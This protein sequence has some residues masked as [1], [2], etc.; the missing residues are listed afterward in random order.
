MDGEEC[1]QGEE[2]EVDEAAGPD[3]VAGVAGVE[4]EE[5]S[6][7]DGD[8]DDDPCGA[9]EEGG[10][11]AREARPQ[12]VKL[13][14]D[15]D[16]PEDR[17]GVEAEAEETVVDIAGEEEE[18]EEAAG[19][20]LG[21]DVHAAEHEHDQEEGDVKGPD[22]KH[23][24]DVEVAHVDGAGIGSL[25]D[26]QLGDEVGAEEEEHADAEGQG[27]A[28]VQEE[29]GQSVAEVRDEGGVVVGDG[30]VEEDGEKGAEAQEVQLW[31]VEARRANGNLGRLLGGWGCNQVGSPAG[32]NFWSRTDFSGN[33]FGCNGNFWWR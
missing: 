31:L 28:D 21:E 33:W 6:G 27:V 1:A 4:A 9:L 13:L 20:K 18:G 8:A 30:V 23:A 22:A 7:Q 12:D 25:K 32:W 11:D 26:E 3:G 14:L 10:A 16:G 24:T 29:G 17:D 19:F 5:D 15:G 2:L